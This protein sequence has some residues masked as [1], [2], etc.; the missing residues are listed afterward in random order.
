MTAQPALIDTNVLCYAFDA[1]EPE[2]RRAG[3][4][5]DSSRTSLPML[6]I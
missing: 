6:A 1:G 4:A 5:G 2:S 3:E